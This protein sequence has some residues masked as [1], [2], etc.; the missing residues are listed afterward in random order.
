MSLYAAKLI[1]QPSAVLRLQ[2]KDPY[3][4]HKV[5]MDLYDL[6]RDFEQQHASTPS[7]VQW[8]DKGEHIYGRE[9]Q[10]L[11]LMPPKKLSFPEDVAFDW[12]AVPENYLQH[13]FYKF[14]IVANP[15]RMA[16]GKRIGLI[17]ES[18]IAEWFSE[19]AN[20]GGFI[21]RSMEIFQNKYCKFYKDKNLVSFAH[22]KISGHLE[23]TNQ[24]LFEKTVE[25][26]IGKGRAFGF[27]LLQLAVIQ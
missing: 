22:T 26:G 20:K 19:K 24:S 23:V 21:V 8:V 11:S 16:G 12:K 14:S 1:L 5:V 7:G 10:L 2:L 9:I 18:D 3:S 17:A 15:C 25:K 13:R 27:G 4:I 6:N